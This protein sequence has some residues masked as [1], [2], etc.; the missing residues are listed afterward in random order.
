MQAIVKRTFNAYIAENRQYDGYDASLATAYNFGFL[1]TAKDN[2]VE[3]HPY[4]PGL[5]ITYWDTSTR[6]T[7]SG[8][9]PGTDWSCPWTPT[10]SSRTGP[11]A[12]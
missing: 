10:R 3:T 12:R 5:L 4:M 9:T 6:T 7:T 1:G 8:S 2:W 11:T